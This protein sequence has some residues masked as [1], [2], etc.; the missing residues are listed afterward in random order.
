MNSEEFPQK[1]LYP[2]SLY[3]AADLAAYGQPEPSIAVSLFHH[4]DQKMGGVAFPPPTVSDFSEIIGAMKSA[5]ARKRMIFPDF[6][7]QSIWPE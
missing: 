3:R 4:Q 2:V 7:P 1:P 5:A 6:Y